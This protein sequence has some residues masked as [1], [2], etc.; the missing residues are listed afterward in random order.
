MFLLNKRQYKLNLKLINMNE[1][2]ITAILT[3]VILLIGNYRK[4]QEE[5]KSKLKAYKEY[6][7]TNDLWSTDPEIAERAIN[8]RSVSYKESI[9]GL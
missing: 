9:N 7:D 2:I 5:S 1:L 4:V 6:L 3:L 8:E